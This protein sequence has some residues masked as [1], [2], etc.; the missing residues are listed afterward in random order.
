MKTIL[1]ILTALLLLAFAMPAA[2]FGPLD[3][4]ASLGLFSKYVWRGIVATDDPVLQPELSA[5]F[6][7]F[8]AGVW[9]NMDLTD[10]HGTELNPD[11]QQGEFN[12]IDY[13]LGYGAAFPFLDFG[14]GLIHYAFPNSDAS[15]TTEFY[16]SAAAHVL[17][18]PSVT[19]YYDIDEIDGGYI[20]L[21]ASHSVALSPMTNLDLAATVGYGSSDYVSGYFGSPAAA[22]A[23][24]T[25]DSG[26][27]DLSLTAS[28]PY[29]PLPI[30]TLTPSVTYTTLM[31]DAK[32]ITDAA[33]G[34][35]D[36]FFF[37]V[38]AGVSF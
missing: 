19:L 27:T 12:E 7:G 38:T 13:T 9:G 5:S 34:D 8:S 37:G 6:L 31:G 22:K 11:G 36:A 28:I 35:K 26:P 20:E 21:G 24:S 14:A 17:F 18:S 29:Q 15:A 25:L 16:V 2:A 1:V 33:G 4:S 3:A 32:D 23:L 30:V 10:I